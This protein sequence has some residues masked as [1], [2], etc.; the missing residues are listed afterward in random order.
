MRC[1]RNSSKIKSE[2]GFIN[3]C[4][5]PELLVFLFEGNQSQTKN[6]GLMKSFSINIEKDN[7]ERNK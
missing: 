5:I 7:F 2:D 1:R 3:C 4:H 6:I